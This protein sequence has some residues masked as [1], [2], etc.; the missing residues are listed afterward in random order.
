MHT[1][2]PLNIG[3]GETNPATR[4]YRA[5]ISYSHADTK[6]ANWLVRRLEGYR[7]PARFHGQVAPLGTV[8]PRIAPVFRDRD[9]LPTTGRLGDTIT[10]ALRESA[11]LVVICSPASA[12]SQWVQQEII[13]FKRL[14][15][16]TPVFAFIV[17]GEPKAA[18]TEADCFSPALRTEVGPDG[19][20]SAISAEVIAADAR[21]HADG[22]EGAFVRLVSGL[23]GVGFDELRQREQTRR[24][25]RM[26]LIATSSALGMAVTLSLAVVAWRARNDAQRRQDKGEDVLAFM[27]GN[28]RSEL[29][30]LG[31]TDLLD[32]VG[33]KAIEYFDTMDPR[34]L[35]DTALARQAKALYQI[36]ENRMEEARY[37]EAA[38][39]YIAAHTRAAALAVRHPG[40]G[41]ILFERAQA[42]FGVGYVNWKRRNLTL[43][44][45]WLTRYRDTAAALVALRPGHVRWIQE[46]A[47]GHQ[48]LAT[49]DIDRRKLAEARAGF[50]AALQNWKNLLAASLQDSELQFNAAESESWLGNVAERSG[51]LSE[52]ALRYREQGLRLDTLIAADP[53]NPRWR[54]RQTDCAVLRAGL[55]SITGEGSAA[56]ELLRNARETIDPLT[57]RDPANR[58]WQRLSANIR[59]HE[60]RLVRAAGDVPAA[61]VV[62]AEARA[63]FEKL[64]AAEPTDW[65][66][67]VRA[68]AARSLEADLLQAAGRPDAA[69]VAERALQHGEAAIQMN[70]GDDIGLGEFA[71]ACVVAGTIA[72]QRDHE[73]ARRHWLRAIEVAGS[74]AKDSA[75]WR[76]LDPVA[77][78]LACLGRADESRALVDRLQRF[79]YRPLQPWPVG[80]A[81][82]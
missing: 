66:Y 41:D 1:R 4:H 71:H 81:S 18:G 50:Q 38:R 26:T 51:E 35:T 59:L 29:K 49:V 19:Q 56:L 3:K 27:L 58:R 61:T 7:V 36:G 24:L 54:F 60:A 13:A 11:T 10:A 75:D 53:K 16:E 31:R 23:L 6:W 80:V 45:Q 42:E 69:A 62:V 22:K 21:P 28:F 34:D 17:G 68:T 67:R 37:V 78:A 25:R 2:A 79:G 46:L 39:A 48:V 15:G 33:D 64:S 65:I 57:V 70:A 43:A 73:A 12:K 74:R 8:G 76:L 52:A 77:R 72:A 44:G 5:F 9:E 40:D 55:Q 82:L 30:K 20:L 63:A 47:S 32:V 14:W